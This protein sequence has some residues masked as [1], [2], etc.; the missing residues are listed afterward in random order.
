MDISHP[1]PASSLLTLYFGV[2]WLASLT[3]SRPPQSAHCLA[4]PPTEKEHTEADSVSKNL[5]PLGSL[6]IRV[7]KSV[8]I[9]LFRQTEL[10]CTDGRDQES[11]ERDL[12][13][14]DFSKGDRM[15]EMEKCKWRELQSEI[16]IVW[17]FC[18]LPTLL[19]SPGIEAKNSLK[20]QGL[21]DLIFCLPFLNPQHTPPSLWPHWT[22]PLP[23]NRFLQG[24]GLLSFHNALS[25]LP[26]SL[27]TLAA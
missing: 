11:L 7:W 10:W 20:E 1:L 21:H 8:H 25:T 6:D 5:F 15:V 16:F 26:A 19:Q 3:S 22:I 23:L 24:C 17:R 9:H 14:K 12:W 2:D 27:P 18:L 13:G 4:S